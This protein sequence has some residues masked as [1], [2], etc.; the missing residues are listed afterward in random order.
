[1]HSPFVF[2]L[3]LFRSLLSCHSQPHYSLPKLDHPLLGLSRTTRA[4]ERARKE[5]EKSSSH[6]GRDPLL[7]G[8]HDAVAREHAQRR[9]GVA[10]GL[11]RVFDLVEPAL[12]TEDGRAGVV[13][14][15]H[16]CGEKAPGENREERERFICL[17]R[18]R[19][20]KKEEKKGRKKGE[21][22]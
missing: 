4:R 7:R 3:S 1:M 6:L 10:D 22:K 17:S 2:F 15:S 16:G 9:A 21:K 12:G 20:K 5:T 11:H 13:A 14:P 8:E 18:A 19:N